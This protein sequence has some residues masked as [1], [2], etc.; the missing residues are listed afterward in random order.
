MFFLAPWQRVEVSEELIEKAEEEESGMLCGELPTRRH[1]PRGRGIQY[2]A[3]SRLITSVS[4]ILDHPPAR[5]MT[6]LSAKG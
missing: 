5:V 6:A 3:A 4:G 2:A 1:T